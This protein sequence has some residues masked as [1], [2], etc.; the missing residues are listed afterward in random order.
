MLAL[1]RPHPRRIG[2]P[3]RR[4]GDERGAADMHAVGRGARPAPGRPDARMTR[5][6]TASAD[7]HTCC[8]RRMTKR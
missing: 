1:A 7:V 4:V 5:K 2:P 8:T 6:K 3:P